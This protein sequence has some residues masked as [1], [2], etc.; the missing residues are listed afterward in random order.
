M[1]TLFKR[2]AVMS[3]ALV[4]LCMTTAAQN[5]KSEKNVTDDCYGVTIGTLGILMPGEIRG[6]EIT[7]MVGYDNPYVI[8]NGQI[9]NAADGI[10]GNGFIGKLRTINGKIYFIEI[11]A[12]D[13]K[14]R[15]EE[16]IFVRAVPIPSEWSLNRNSTQEWGARLNIIVD[17]D[18]KSKQ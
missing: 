8:Y 9:V 17:P 6:V 10:I 13:V 12:R 4:L 3:T 14:E 2:M 15:T 7:P 5:G 11:I 1:K 16:A 18:I